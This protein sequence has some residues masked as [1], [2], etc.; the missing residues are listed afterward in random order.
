MGFTMKGLKVKGE[1]F[2]GNRV[3][4]YGL[5]PVFMGKPNS[6]NKLET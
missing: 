3:I 1:T 4:G 6:F 5:S 2:Q